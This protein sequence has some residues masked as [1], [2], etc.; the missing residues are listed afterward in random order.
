MKSFK[1]LIKRIYQSFDLFEIFLPIINS[2]IGLGIVNLTS[3]IE[4]WYQFIQFFLFLLFINFGSQL[5]HIYITG[6]ANLMLDSKRSEYSRILYLLILFFFGISILPL[7]RVL[8][9]QSKNYFTINL[10]AI[11]TVTSLLWRDID[12]IVKFSGLGILSNSILNGSII[13]MTIIS[14]YG[15]EINKLILA[16]SQSSFFILIGSLLI[17]DVNFEE[18]M[19]KK[20]SYIELIGSIPALKIA[21]TSITVGV[22]LLIINFISNTENGRFHPSLFTLPLIMWMFTTLSI[23]D[24]K[25]KFGLRILNQQ[26]LGLLFIYYL[27]WGFYLWV[28]N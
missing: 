17:R 25:R 13:P 23:I 11:A 26:S 19:K 18:N 14:L 22:L 5:L 27:G 20:V 6:T 2:F 21:F 7:T 8:L 24:K 3:S 1:L 10:I 15:I 28:I 4:N 9:G 16:F 12:K